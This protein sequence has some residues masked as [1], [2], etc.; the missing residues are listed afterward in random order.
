[1]RSSS[2][3]VRGDTLDLRI[4]EQA[5]DALFAAEPALLESAER[6]LHCAAGAPAVDVDLTRI[7]AQRDRDRGVDVAREDAGVQSVLRRVG[8][9][10]RFLDIVERRDRERRTEDFLVKDAVRRGDPRHQRRLREEAVGETSVGRYRR[11]THDR[12][13]FRCGRGDR[14]LDLVAVPGRIQRPHVEIVEREQRGRRERGTK[15]TDS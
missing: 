11:V 3:E 12:R 6:H 15:V 2:S 13:A 8:E 10:D 1:M 14:T 4:V 7:D 9:R 5:V